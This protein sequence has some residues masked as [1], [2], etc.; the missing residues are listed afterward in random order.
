MIARL[1]QWTG[2]AL[3]ALILAHWLSAGQDDIIQPYPTQ[4]VHP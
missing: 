2:L 1:G 3:G 4:E